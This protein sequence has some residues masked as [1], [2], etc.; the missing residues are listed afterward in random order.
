MNTNHQL[1]I[2]NHQ[3]KRVSSPK[4][5]VCC[6]SSLEEARAAIEHGADALGLV[7]PMPSGPGVIDDDLIAEIAASV[8][9]VETFLLTSETSADEVIS[10]HQK[11]RTT[12]IQLVDALE[13][14]THED[15]R[16]AIPGVTLVQVVHVMGSRSVDEALEAAETADYVLLDS[17]NPLLDT[18]ELG[19]TGRT[20][21]WEISRRIVEAS[22]KPVF[23][24]GGLNPDNIRQAIDDV[25]PYGIDLCSGVRTE[26]AL[27]KIKLRNFV[28]RVKSETFRGG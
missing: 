3:S 26:G 19:G 21:N 2:L 12:T 17:G 13:V 7:G 8:D 23:L 9:S 28:S 1:S 11:V 20:H 27:D 24:A 14:G 10:H 22:E 6:I 25:R 4:I 16:S 5:K 15:I 18:K